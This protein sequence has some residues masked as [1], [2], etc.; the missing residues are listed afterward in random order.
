MSTAQR[1]LRFCM[2]TTFYPPYAFGGDEHGRL[3]FNRLDSFF[4]YDQI[5][6]LR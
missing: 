3:S 1:K 2:I 5:S 6:V 4:W